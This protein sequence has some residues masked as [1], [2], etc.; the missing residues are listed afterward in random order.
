MRLD[1]PQPTNL[2]TVDTEKWKCP[3]RPL[4]VPVKSMCRWVIGNGCRCK[5][6]PSAGVSD[7]RKATRCLP[8]GR[9]W[10][11]ERGR[12]GANDM[13]PWHRL[14]PEPI[15]AKRNNLA[16]A[17][18][19]FFVSACGGGAADSRRRAP[20]SNAT[21]RSGNLREYSARRV[22]SWVAESGAKRRSSA[23]AC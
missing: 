14:T 21:D 9:R 20:H 19:G 18:S 13:I 1:S 2:P 11:G 12:F 8:F 4:G 5:T 7:L 6:W 23:R 22:S 10:S 16:S 17:H 3:T 15:V